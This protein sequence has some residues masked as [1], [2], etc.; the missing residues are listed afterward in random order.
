M[1]RS[2]PQL[3]LRIEYNISEKNIFFGKT[4]KKLSANIQKIQKMIFFEDDNDK[5][6]RVENWWEAAY[7]GKLTTTQYF[8]WEVSFGRLVLN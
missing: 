4:Y 2:F 1:Q 6:F 3:M 7:A 8:L 5:N